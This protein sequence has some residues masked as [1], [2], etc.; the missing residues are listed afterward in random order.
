MLP[1]VEI[2]PTVKKY[3]EGY[4]DL[5]SPEQFEHF[6]R[7]LT[8]LFVSENKTIQ[9]INGSFVIE[10]KN[11]SSLNRFFT[12]YA[13]SA[14]A[15]NER[16]LELLRQT[17]ATTPKKHAVLI[18]DD[19][20]NE[21]YGEHF[22]LLG[23]WFIPSAKR[24]G[25]SHN[26]VTLHYADRKVDYPLELRWY[27]QM[28]VDQTVEWIKEHEIKYR[29]EVLERK[30]KESQ[31]RKYLADILKRV[32]R[33]HPD[34]EVPFPSKLDLA[35]DLIDWAVEQGYRYP[36]VMDSWYTCRQF[37]EHIAGKNMIYV[38]TVEPDDGIYLKGKWVSI[39]DWHAQL[40]DQAF[41]PVHF[42]YRQRETLEKYWA[43][44]QTQ[45]V[46]QLGRVRLVASHKEQDR[47]DKPRFFVCNY[48]QWEL[49]YLL[50]RRQLRWPVE[51]GYE[52]TK[53]PLGFDAYELRDEEGIRRHW[54]L[55]FAAYSAARQ[56]NA[57]GR[58]GNWL[59]AKLQTVGEVSRQ[60]QGEA[61]AAL[62]CYALS[63]LT[64]GRSTKSI[65]DLLVS[66]LRQ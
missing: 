6:R 52:D 30:Q 51:T 35:C 48:L 59:K 2:P 32:R 22:P 34:W 14:T 15:I 5:F 3:A 40:S 43:A 27:D 23:K 18:V 8:G 63:E 31:K 10:V 66:H 64:Q 56:A 62:I 11:Q 61:M 4:Q 47:S 21:K 38:G 16:R 33:D 60:V 28:D 65:V 24:Y 58:W 1:L 7:Y 54:T 53:G 9:A 26:V 20:H 49:S 12:E 25:F 17:P 50:G 45:Q 39:K 29:P 37:C 44:A 46:D 19:T 13:W 57:Q 42:R 36:V 55:V 41:E